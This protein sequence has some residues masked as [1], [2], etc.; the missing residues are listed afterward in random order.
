MT[1]TETK[2]GFEWRCDRC[3]L[4]AEFPPLDFWR[5][6]SE[7]KHRGWQFDRYDE[8]EGRGGWT[9]WCA[10]CERKANVGIL[11]RPLVRSV[12]G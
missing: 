3:G 4:V 10:K 2:E 7:L 6:V 12:K 1:F 11:D 8:P 9:H 5:A